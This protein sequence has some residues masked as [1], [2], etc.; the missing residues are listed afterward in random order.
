MKYERCAPRTHTVVCIYIIL[1]IVY[2][3]YGV[4][5]YTQL[6]QQPQAGINNSIIDHWYVNIVILTI[7]LESL[8]SII[9]RKHPLSLYHTVMYIQ[10]YSQ[11]L[12]IFHLTGIMYIHAAPLQPTTCYMY[13]I[14][15][16]IVS[17]NTQHELHYVL[18]TYNV[19]L[20]K[21]VFLLLPDL[22]MD[23]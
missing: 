20:F 18:F 14:S 12:Y 11:S 23:V 6:P 13:T 9:C 16:F 21:C 8:Y 15:H 7:S 1:Y 2:T 3:L 17:C 5:V 22:M 10:T 4:Y 19:V